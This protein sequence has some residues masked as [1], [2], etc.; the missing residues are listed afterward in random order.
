LLA[1]R[2]PPL[3]EREGGQGVSFLKGLDEKNGGFFTKISRVDI[4]R[5]HGAAAIENEGIPSRQTISIQF[6][7]LPMLN[8][9]FSSRR[10]Q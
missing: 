8:M 5:F 4:Y 2:F 6:A 9:L 3:L 7:F 10:I 1:L